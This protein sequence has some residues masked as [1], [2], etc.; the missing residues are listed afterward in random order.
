MSFICTAIGREGLAAEYSQ[1]YTAIANTV[2]E[3]CYDAERGLYKDGSVTRSFSMHTVVWAILS[4]VAPRERWERLISH[5]YDGDLAKCSFSMNY[6]TFRALEKS[7]RRDMIFS[8]LDG[9]R[10]MIDLGC[11]TWCENPD[12]PRSECHGWSSTPLYE[13]SSSILGVSTD[14]SDRITISPSTVHLT[15]AKGAVPTRFGTVKVYWTVKDGVFSLSVSG[16]DGTEKLVLLPN[17]ESHSFLGESGSFSC[18]I[19]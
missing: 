11:T 13:F 15:F 9:W 16:A 10:K 3:L 19:S 14:I 6:F 5:L 2:N 17:G 8:L 7:G 4:E 1:R 12:S 18:S